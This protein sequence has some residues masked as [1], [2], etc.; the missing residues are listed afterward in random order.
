[1][2]CKKSSYN[3]LVRGNSIQVMIIRDGRI[4]QSINP[5]PNNRH[6]E[7]VSWT[8][9]GVAFVQNNISMMRISSTQQIMHAL[10][11]TRRLLEDKSALATPK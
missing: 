11:T 4:V 6:V 3:I 8:P 10:E 1:M 2:W 5:R 7:K 9:R